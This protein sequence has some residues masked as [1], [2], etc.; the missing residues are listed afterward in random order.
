[1]I[2]VEEVNFVSVYYCSRASCEWWGIFWLFVFTDATTCSTSPEITNLAGIQISVRMFV[3]LMR[4]ASYPHSS[5]EQRGAV[6]Q[7]RIFLDLEAGMSLL[8][9]HLLAIRVTSF[10]L[11][12]PCLDQVVRFG[13]PEACPF[14]RR[15]R[16]EFVAGLTLLASLRACPGPRLS[17]SINVYP[18]V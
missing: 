4:M 1:M 8:T 10:W 9:S 5:F 16:R 17:S 12:I 7:V 14:A 11:R 6:I 18:G 15:Q 2:G 3:M 13:L